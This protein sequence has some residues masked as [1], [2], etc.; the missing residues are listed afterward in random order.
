MQWIAFTQWRDVKRHAAERGIGLMGDIPFGVSA[1]SADAWAHPQ[2]F[3]TG[4]C[5]G[6]PPDRIFKHDPFVQKWGQ[7]WGIPLYDWE[8]HR[9]QG[10]QWWRQ[11]VR[12]VREFFDLFRIDH[13]LGFYRIYGFPWQPQR[14]DEF[15]PL[16][17]A[18]ARARSGGESPHFQPRADDTR[19]HKEQN[20]REGE[21]YLRAV[22]QEAGPGSVIGEDLGEVPDYVR[23][24]LKK[25]GIAGYKVPQWE[26]RDDG[27][28]IPGAEYERLSLAT[29]ATHDHDPLRAMWE[30]LTR[31]AAGPHGDGARWERRILAEYAGLPVEHL[32]HAFT[33]KVHLALIGALFKS[34][35]WIAILMITDLFGRA[36]RFNS[37]GVAGGAN[38]TQRLHAPV[39]ELIQDPILPEVRRLLHE[40]G[41]REHV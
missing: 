28:L 37:P 32:P 16:S 18:E 13:V 9:A 39:S 22:L 19:E 27:H 23:P 20:C 31:D 26:K 29:Y 21:E 33:P 35:A 7:N 10:F 36:E 15:L 14:N 24:N 34:N 5:G 4:W 17:E 8:A 2:L 6:T 30:Q 41:R 25:L 12:G 38:W 1:Q 11:R 3:R 40:T